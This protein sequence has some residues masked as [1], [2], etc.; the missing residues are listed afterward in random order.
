MSI[1][2]QF[3]ESTRRPAPSSWGCT[4]LFATPILNDP[5]VVEHHYEPGGEMPEHAAAE[6]VLCICVGG[7]G[8]VKVGGDTSELSANQAIV[9]PSTTTHKL[10]T[11]DSSMTVLLVHFPGRA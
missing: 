8:F 3:G 9:W 11:H 7:H 4:N 5:L 1:T 6:T 2:I 10:W